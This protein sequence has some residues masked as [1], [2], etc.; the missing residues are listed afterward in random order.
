MTLSCWESSKTSL[1]DQRDRAVHSSR[2][3]QAGNNECQRLHQEIGRRDVG[4]RDRHD[5]GRQDKIGADGARNLLVLEGRVSQRELDGLLNN[6]SLKAKWPLSGEP[7]PRALIRWGL[8]RRNNG[9]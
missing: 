7:K 9:K 3:Q 8:A 5:L 6:E 4:E 1:H 2:D